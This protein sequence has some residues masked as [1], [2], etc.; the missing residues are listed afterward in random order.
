MFNNVVSELYALKEKYKDDKE[1]VE[2]IDKALHELAAGMAIVIDIISK[3]E[4]DYR[5]YSH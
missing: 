1:I 5:K 2:S 3:K 4:Y